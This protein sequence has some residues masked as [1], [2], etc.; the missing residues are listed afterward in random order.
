MDN[1][2]YYNTI[3]YPRTKLTWQQ[4]T[5]NSV[6][7]ELCAT[8][9][10]QLV[11]RSAAAKSSQ[12]WDMVEW[13]GHLVWG[14]SPSIRLGAAGWWTTGKRSH[15][16]R[17]EESLLLSCWLSVLAALFRLPYYT[18]SIILELQILFEV[19]PRDNRME[20]GPSHTYWASSNFLVSNSIL[21]KTA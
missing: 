1:Y 3:R 13:T 21:S 20:S 6:K 7:H 9:T 17:C 5:W 10:W 2:T 12:T 4:Q 19:W 18:C 14:E 11:S 16:P 15:S 8:Q